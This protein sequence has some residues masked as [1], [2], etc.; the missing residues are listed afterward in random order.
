MDSVDLA[1][2]K[3]L[4]SNGRASYSSIARSV[5]LSTS[6]V[7]ARVNN[8]LKEGIIDRFLAR[9]NLASLGYRVIHIIVKHDGNEHELIKRLGSV[10]YV[11]MIV[12]CLGDFSVF[13]LA[14][15]K[16]ARSRSNK[17]YHAL[18]EQYIKPNRILYITAVKARP[19]RLV[20]NDLRIMKYLTKDPRAKVKDIARELGISIKTVERRLSR[21][22]KDDIIK[23]TM[24]INPSLK[25]FINFI[26]VIRVSNSNNN[27]NITSSI[28]GLEN[29]LSNNL[30]MPLIHASYDTLVAVL[31]AYNTDEINMLLK[32][33]KVLEGVKDVE[34]FIVQKI[35]SDDCSKLIDEIILNSKK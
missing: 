7:I 8:M 31:H 24:I 21:M 27:N 32:R 10:G 1:I 19:K 35:V 14:V 25:N 23:F 33:V 28:E 22:I 5:G 29:I 30:L 26:M 3:L 9:I 4:I 17:G 34:F 16:E 20:Y 15:N 11:F 6:S 2:I 18:L 13:A 12:T